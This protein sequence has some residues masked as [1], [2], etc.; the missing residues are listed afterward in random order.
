MRRA[1]VLAS[2][3]LTALLAGCGASSSTA[4]P[5]TQPA[6]KQTARLGWVESTG[7]PRSRLVF[8]VRSFVVTPDGWSAD[9][10]VTNDTGASFGIDGLSN[11]PG[12]A[13]GLMLFRTGS[14]DELEQRNRTLALPVLRPAT[15][16]APALPASLV[17][18][19]T[20]TGTVSAHGA[21]PSGLWVRLVFGTF[22]PEDTMP[23]SLREQGVRSDVIW[24][25][26]H[27][28]R[29]RR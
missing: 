27:T 1:T 6:G 12:N 20:W 19:S 5:V 14:H 25:T 22:V 8:R 18:R 2:L 3:A 28:Y 13:F 17:P 16:V 29:L 24:I 23:D 21:L 11:P 9:V 26:D 4:V 15:T 10:S 7:S